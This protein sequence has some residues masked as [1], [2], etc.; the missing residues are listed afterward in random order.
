MSLMIRSDVVCRRVG[1]NRINDL[2]ALE[3]SCFTSD[4]SNRRNLQHLLQSPSAY[5]LGAYHRGELVGSMVILFKSNS[6]SARIYSLA[7]SAAARGLGIARRMMARAEREAR[8][9]GCNR[10]RLEVRMDNLPA[11]RLYER[12]GFT[13]AA[14]LSGYYDDGAHAFVMRKDLV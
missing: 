6:R 3:E 8:K 7:V 9:R 12:L 10:M 4:R 1:L 2:L 11:I 5:C 13:D 14:V